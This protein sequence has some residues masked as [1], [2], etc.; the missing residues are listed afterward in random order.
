MS[1]TV[2]YPGQKDYIQ[3]MNDLWDRATLALT[4]TST[5][6][7]LV[8]TGSKS[9]TTDTDRQ[10]PVGSPVLAMRTSN[11]TGVWVYGTVTSYDPDT[12]ALV[13]NSTVTSGSGTY[14]DWTITVSGVRGA[15]GST[16]AAGLTHRGA[17]ASATAY[18]V[19]DAVTY[20]GGTYRRKVAGTTATAPSS[21]TTNWE[22]LAAKG[23]TG[24]TGPANTLTIGTVTTGAAGSAA[25]ATVTGTA[26]NQTLNLTIPQGIQGIQGVIGPAGLVWKGAWVSGTTYAINDAVTNS[27]SS[28]RRKVAGAGTTAPGSDATNW[29]LIA[30]KGAD[31]TGN[32]SSVNSIA[33]VAGNVTLTASDVGALPATS[34]NLGNLDTLVGNAVFGFSDAATGAPPIGGGAY[35]A[36]GLQ[37][38]HATGQR[39]QL[40]QRGAGVG[41]EWRQ[42]DSG[43]SSGGSFDAWKTI[44]DSTN[45]PITLGGALTTAGAFATTFTMTGATNVTFPTSGILLSTAATVTVGQG[46]TG[47]T[48]WTTNGLVYASGSTT[49]V[50]TAA[51]AAKTVLV[52]TGGAPSF[53]TLDLTYMPTSWTKHSVR[54]ASTANLTVTATATTLTNSGTLAALVLDGITVAAGDRVLIMDQTTGSQNGI[55]DV[56]DPGSASVAWVL[57]RA[58]GANSALELAGAAVGIDSGTAKGSRRYANSM[59]S[60]DTVGT[61][62]M[63]WY[64]VLDDSITIAAN[65]GGTGQSSYTVGDILYAS[66]TTTLSKLAAGGAGTVLM[67]NGPG[68]A[69]SYGTLDLSFLPTAWTK[70]SCRVATT[71]ALSGTYASNVLTGSMAALIIDGVTLATGNRVLVKN[72]ASALQNGLYY[73]SNP[74]VAGTTAWTLTR[75]PDCNFADEMANA[76]VAVDE[77][78]QNGLWV[79]KFKGTDTVGTST[80]VWHRMW[81][82]DNPTIV[83][84]TEAVYAPAA[85]S[86]FTVDL[87]NG[88]IQR[89]TTNANTTITLPAAVAGKSYI[90]ELIYGGAH[91]VTFA[92]GTAIKWPGDT[93][94][95]V[96]SVSG[97]RDKFSFI[98]PTSSITDGSVIGLNYPA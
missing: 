6:S 86:A 64:R 68:V 66:G 83:T 61:T 24:N 47:R 50:S 37:I 18:V 43:N 22:L 89:F 60:T 4:G 42:D 48:S 11:P 75:V 84:Y 15:T 73:V 30:Q 94:P 7:V 70:K 16:G 28:Y 77:G 31:G 57:T 5:S 54:C 40:V 41:W 59:K 45:L 92:G 19:N 87:A 78:T 9:F 3:K 21:D 10:W 20:G 17:W 14:T 46:G 49:L 96:T 8:G 91:T 25:A 34:P 12:G 27:G 44:W 63:T 81:D 62:T 88:P 80:V 23:D 2:F 97:K 51:G 79:T 71:V 98:C 58:A 1:T 76:V 35:D 85:G 69:P 72:Q 29:E 32:V 65:R 67:G 74:G 53:A 26:P 36:A 33:P 13:M 56:T 95:T 90:I 52:G 38:T 39:T 82:G 93:A 55:Y